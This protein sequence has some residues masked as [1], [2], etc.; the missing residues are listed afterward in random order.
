MEELLS[1]EAA[2]KRLGGVSKFTIHAWLSQGRL[3][4]T[5][6]GGRTM[7]AASELEK[8]VERGGKSPAPR[9]ACPPTDEAPTP[10]AQNSTPASSAGAGA[11]DAR[12]SLLQ[13]RRRR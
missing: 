7:V 3:A 9:R 11:L 4:R 8:V 6:V 12:P 2:A 10:A 1:V 5:K 13:R